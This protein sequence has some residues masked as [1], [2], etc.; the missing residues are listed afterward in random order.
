MSMDQT[1]FK[2]QMKKF[3]RRL[4]LKVLTLNSV[5]LMLPNIFRKICLLPKTQHVAAS[6][7]PFSSGNRANGPTNQTVSIVTKNLGMSEDGFSHIYVSRNGTPESN[8]AKVIDTMGGIENLIGKDAIVILKPNAQWWNQGGTNTDAM[9]EFIASVLKIPNFKGEVIIA[10]NHHLNPANSRGWTQKEYNNGSYNLNDLV[11]YF[12][13]RGNSN[14][15]K[16]HWIDAERTKYNGYSSKG[17]VQGPEDGDG[18]VWRKD[19]IYQTPSGRKAVMSYPV[20]TSSFSGITIDLKNGAWKNG[21][22]IDKPIKLVNFSALNHHSK[23]F[24]VTASVKNYLGI[25]DLTCGFS[26]KTLK[27]LFKY[28]YFNFHYIGCAP[29]LTIFGKTNQLMRNYFKKWTNFGGENNHHYLGGAVGRFARTVRFPDLNIITAEWVGYGSRLNLD[30]RA[31]TRTI[32][33]SRD[34][35]AL[36]Y[37][38][39]KYVLLP[40]TK[41]AHNGELYIKLN[42]PTIT[43]NPF[44]KYLEECHKQGI[45]TLDEKEMIIHEHD[46]LKTE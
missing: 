25:V 14:I 28:D 27:G 15:T 18:Y 29:N 22:Y 9:K 33:A 37:Y 46:F 39:A 11:G 1:F 36:D 38:A 35:L 10:E 12:N 16:Y 41:D 45:G 2:V 21:R 17:I 26:G 13:E 43:E 6:T 23:T 31:Q 42:D 20:F 44:R 5:L 8:M 32:L 30:L 24:G 34:P 3:T 4:F 40:A 19:N 7:L